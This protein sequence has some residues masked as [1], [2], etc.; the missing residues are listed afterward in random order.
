METSA[1]CAQAKTTR[2][3]A[4]TLL[5]ASL[6]AAPPSAEEVGDPLPYEAALGDP[7]FG[8]LVGL[9]Q[10][11]ARGT[12]SGDHLRQDMAR[13]GKKSR[14]PAKRLGF[15]RRE[16]GTDGSTAIVLRLDGDMDLPIPY[17]ILWYHPGSMIA[18]RETVFEER[19]F[20]NMAV[21]H[22]DRATAPERS[23]QAE[24]V[25]LFRLREG[26]LAIDIDAWLDKLMGSALDDTE[27]STLAIARYQGRWLGLAIGKNRK[28]EP[29]SGVF[30]MVADK[31][32]FP[33]P[34]DVRTIAR[35]IRGIADAWR[36]LGTA[37]M[38][39]APVRGGA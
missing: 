24:D 20:G 14:L 27:V 11:D 16:A 4:A 26:R 13:L 29:R 38:R 39:T 18:S 5:A 15:L 28:G 34:S 3:L 22:K 8:V 9:I 1:G 23:L 17:S 21:N 33:V 31:V 37:P 30:D 25:R 12:L 6:G 2:A 10:S 36:P 32:L 35:A 19:R 7:V